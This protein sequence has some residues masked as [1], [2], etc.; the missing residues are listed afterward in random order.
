MDINRGVGRAD[1]CRNLSLAWGVR[2]FGNDIAYPEDASAAAE[3]FVRAA[4]QSTQS[5][6]PLATGVGNWPYER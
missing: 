4:E 2:F 6:P 1:F 5:T 3:T